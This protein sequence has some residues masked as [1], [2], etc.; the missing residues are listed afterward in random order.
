MK[1]W[2][3]WCILLTGILSFPCIL[4]GAVRKK[5]KRVPKEEKV[6]LSEYDKLFKGKRYESAIGE[7]VAVHKMDGKLYIEYPLRLL[8]REL[9]LASTTTSST[10]HSVCTNGFKEN[11]PLHIRFVLKDGFVQL[12][13]INA[14][15]ETESDK[16]EVSLA[17]RQN[18]N[19]PVIATYKVLAY[20]PDSLAVVFEMTGMF[21]NE[22]PRLSP[23][24]QESGVMRVTAA[25][26]SNLSS[27][28]EVKAFKDNMS[29]KSQLNYTYTVA[30]DRLAL[31]KDQPLTVEVTRTLLLLP[32]Q[33]MKPRLSDSRIGTFLTI[34]RYLSESGEAIGKYSYAN[35]WR[36]EPKDEEAYLS[37]ELTEPVKPIVFY[38]DPL[39]PEAWK[40]PIREGV[41]KWNK[42]FEKIGFKNV[43][44]VRDFPTDDRSFDPDNLKYSCIHYVPTAVANAMGPSWVDPSTGEILNASVLIYNDVIKMIR[45]WRF[46]QTAQVDPSVRG[47][48]LPVAILNESLSYVVSHEIG[49]CLG[50]M[51]NMAASAAYP[52]DS[53]RSASFTR[54]YGTTPSIMDYARFNYVAQPGD[55]GV[56]LTPPDLGGYDEFVIR[57]LYTSFATSTTIW[58]EARTLEA[59]VDEKA[60]DSMYRYGRQ[61]VMGRY[62]PSALEE[63][64][65]DD[66]LKAGEYGIQNLKYILSRLNEWI[67]DDPTAEYRR[68]LYDQMVSQYYR[69]IRNVMYNIGGVYLSDAKEDSRYKRHQSVSRE[70]QKAS[71]V[72]VLSQL[73]NSTWIDDPEVLRK[74]PLGMTPSVTLAETLGKQLFL[75]YKQ[76]TLSASLSDDPYTVEEYFDDLYR[77]VWESAIQNRRLTTIDM[78]LQSQSLAPLSEQVKTIGGKR[79]GLSLADIYCYGLDP[80]GMTDRYIGSL[81]A[82]EREESLTGFGS[83]YGWQRVLDTQAMEEAPAYYLE[84]LMKI[85]DLLEA[86]METFVGEDQPHYQAMLFAVKHVLGKLAQQN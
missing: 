14:L 37:G 38:I 20:T 5:K 10:D 67:T 46:V 21:L 64:L 28:K 8:G 31:V 82:V 71:V 39:F 33:K 80:T 55:Q 62:D 1:K 2:I 41:L 57:W 34:K 24:P 52:V 79:V 83:G 63:D 78:I 3:V 70:I 86:R 12:R 13:E 30:R 84:M 4:E 45:N 6:E 42:A 53:L 81:R 59:W 18:F 23:I 44:Q 25:Y 69:Y 75:L 26:T 22:E 29:V 48:E 40:N 65:G 74:L 66:P 9:L 43:M 56:K 51:H 32:E 60:N 49:H 15:Y 35:R 17:I 11:I 76:V 16:A 47:K 77:D 68:Q 54:K 19:D 50:L 7:F 36:L 85:K 27:I 61:Q 73:K 58:D 72:W